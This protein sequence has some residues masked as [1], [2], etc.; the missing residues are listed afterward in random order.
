MTIFVTTKP[1]LP[2]ID[3]ALVKEHLRII[4]S[5]DDLTLALYRDAAIEIFENN[6]NLALITQTLKQVIDCFPCG[7]SF[8]LLERYPIITLTHIKYYDTDNVLQ[9][10]GSTNYILESNGI[11]PKLSLASGKSWPSDIHPTRNNA[12][13]ITYQAG[14][15][16]TDTSVPND[17]KLALSLIIG[18]FFANREDSVVQP[19]IG[20]INTFWNSKVLL[21]RYKPY[22]FEHVSQQRGGIH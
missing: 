17:V 10:W 19:G 12:V 13:E 21:R 15:G 16:A 6:A 14:Y 8:F 2:A 3:L 20:I 9:T 5:D 22:Y 7:E 4:G 1:V 18:D 11:P